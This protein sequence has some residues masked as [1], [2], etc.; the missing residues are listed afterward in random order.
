VHHFMV[1]RAALD[2]SEAVY[3]LIK[4]SSLKQGDLMADKMRKRRPKVKV[5]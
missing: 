3:W 4:N 5:L 2:Y 1:F